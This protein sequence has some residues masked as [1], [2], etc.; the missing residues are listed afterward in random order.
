MLSGISAATTN[1]TARQFPDNLIKVDPACTNILLNT[2]TSVKNSCLLLLARVRSLPHPALLFA[3][4]YER[5]A[6]KYGR[7]AIQYVHME[8]GHA[9]QNICLQSEASGLATV[10]IG[11]FDDQAVS[12]L[13]DLREGEQPL[14]I[15]PI[16]K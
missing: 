1:C 4:D 5:C 16:G 11:A 10:C 14:Y 2:A 8:T 13:F 9:A 7:R 15:M 12:R 6:V 3:A